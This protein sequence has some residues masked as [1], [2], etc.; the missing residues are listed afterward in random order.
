MNLQFQP[1]GAESLTRHLSGKHGFF[2]ITHTAG[3]GQ[4][5]NTREFDMGQQVIVLVIE[6]HALHG[7][8]NHLCTGGFNG[9]RHQFIGIELASA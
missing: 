6:F 4:Q 3:V 2:G 1:I 5:L 7:H 9:L 8:R